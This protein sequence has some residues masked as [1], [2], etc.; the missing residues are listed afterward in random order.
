MMDI[1]KNG[2]ILSGRIPGKTEKRDPV[3]R[4]L[5]RLLHTK[6]REKGIP[7]E[8][9][10]ELTPLC[11][12][13]CKMCYVHLDPDQMN[14]RSILSVETWKDLMRQAWEAGMMN[15]TLTGGECLTYPGFSELFLY[16]HS[17]GCEVNVLTNGLLLNEE[18]IRFFKEHMPAAIQITL[19]GWNDDVY[20]RVTGQRAFVRVTNNIRRAIDAGLPVHVSITPSIYL[21]E[22]LLGTIRAAKEL[23]K[24]VIISNYFTAPREETGRSSQQDD[25]DT[26]LY[27]R[28][29][30]YYHKLDGHEITWVSEDKLPPCGGPNHETSECGFRCGG[31]RSGFAIDWEGTMMP[32]SN[33]EQIKSYPLKDGFA[34]AWAKVNYEVNHWPRIPEC[35][36]CAYEDVCNH[37][38]SNVMRFAEPGKVPTALCERTREMVRRGVMHIPECE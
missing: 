28:G 6:A 4:D 15:C 14:S 12:F 24:S 37:C 29:L 30:Q 9:K 3:F 10:F 27:I 17:L 18:R 23:C 2:P 34:A 11:N 13:S 38:A 33:F 31:G 8:G 19:Y 21:G 16:L 22:D 36:G 25:V 1:S 35:E 26:D 20:E 32:C 5:G 7:I